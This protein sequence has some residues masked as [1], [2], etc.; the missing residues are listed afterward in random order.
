[1]TPKFCPILSV[2]LLYKGLSLSITSTG[3]CSRFFL[4][5]V[6]GASFS[7][8]FFLLLPQRGLFRKDLVQPVGVQVEWGD[9]VEEGWQH[10]MRDE[11]LLR[12]KGAYWG[13]WPFVFIEDISRDASAQGVLLRKIECFCLM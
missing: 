7:N 2:F 8:K 3:S 12:R 9:P 4:E 13:L 5:G 10:H 1:M 6:T 11:W